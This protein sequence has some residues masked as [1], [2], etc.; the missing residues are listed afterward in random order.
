M[1]L[2]NTRERRIA[3]IRLIACRQSVLPRV[4][5]RSP[6]E[7]AASC[8]SLRCDAQCTIGF[9][10][11]VGQAV[12]LSVTA[13]SPADMFRSWACTPAGIPPSYRSLHPAS[14]LHQLQRCN[15]MALL[16]HSSR[17]CRISSQVEL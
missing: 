2:K 11:A 17:R 12:L 8:P 13:S 7:S 10:T 5:A 3:P 9:E 16:L 15:A 6:E 4:P 1:I 14:V